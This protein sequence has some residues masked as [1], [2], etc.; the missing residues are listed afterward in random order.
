MTMRQEAAVAITLS[1]FPYLM[2]EDK[3]KYLYILGVFLGGLIHNAAFL[4]A[5]LFLLKSKNQWGYNIYR[6]L[7][8]SSILIILGVIMYFGFFKILE[9]YPVY[10]AAY[11]NSIQTDGSMPHAAGSLTI[12]IRNV[13]LYLIPYVGIL[14]GMKKRKYTLKETKICYYCCLALLLT[15]VFNTIGYNIAIVYR[16]AMVFEYFTSVA[17]TM[18]LA[19]FGRKNLFLKYFYVVMLIL[20]FILRLNIQFQKG[21]MTDYTIY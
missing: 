5:I 8:I 18:F 19:I 7:L 4:L 6:I 1:F 14:Y 20:Y 2:Y 17:L 10:Y 11:N 13:F 12:I 9:L 21:M 16:L 3:K 15:F